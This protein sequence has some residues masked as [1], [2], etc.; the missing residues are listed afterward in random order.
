MHNQRE[1]PLGEKAKL[2]APTGLLSWH[3]GDLTQKESRVHGV[4]SRKKVDHPQG[5]L[6]PL[7]QVDRPTGNPEAVGE[8]LET[9][10]SLAARLLS[11]VC[12]IIA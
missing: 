10:L 7:T 3:T 8:A 6:H 1:T 4:P 5:R 9:C 12:S 11:F 2:T